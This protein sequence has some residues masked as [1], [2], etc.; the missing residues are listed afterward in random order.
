MLMRTLN[1]SEKQH[2]KKAVSNLYPSSDLRQ[3]IFIIA[4]YCV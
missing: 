1:N 3:R 4:H 2:F